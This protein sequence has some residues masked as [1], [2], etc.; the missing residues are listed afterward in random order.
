[1]F[2]KFGEFNS[3]E[4][5]NTAAANQLKEGDVNAIKEIAEENG[6]DPMD[7]EDF[8]AGDISELCNALTAALGKLQVETKDLGIDALM[9]DW[10]SYIEGLCTDNKECALA[11]RRKDKSLAGVIGEI[12]KES[13]KV[14]FEVDKRIIEAAGITNKAGRITFGIPEEARV[15]E[16]IKEYYLGGNADE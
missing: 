5:I 10:V 11:V 15:R 13:W 14:Q 16:I 2:D 9:L 8:I 12:L 4:E 3:F 7:A 6:L 1:M